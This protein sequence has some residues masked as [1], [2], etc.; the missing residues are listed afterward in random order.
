MS[1]TLTTTLSMFKPDFGHVGWRELYNTNLDI[2][3]TR[4]SVLR[5]DVGNERLGIGTATPGH[6]V[7]IAKSQSGN[8]T[9]L[10]VYN[11]NGTNS[12]ESA[13]ISLGRSA[14]QPM[15]S[16]LAS[17]FSSGTF[18]NGFLAFLTYTSNALTEKMRLTHEGNLGLG[19]TAPVH[20]FEAVG[21]L[22]SRVTESVGADTRLLF[23]THN[24]AAS[25][26][27]N[28][29][30]QILGFIEDGG[31]NP[32]KGSLRLYTNAGDNSVERLRITPDGSMLVGAGAPVAT[33]RFQID[34]TT[35]GLLPPRMTTTQRDAIGSPNVGLLI[36]N[37][38][39][40]KLNVRGASAW[41][42]VTSA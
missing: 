32:L 4:F 23:L 3:D 17:N 2:L 15:G 1:Y 22:V 20:T 11:S 14:T 38:T 18:A 34:S 21:Y 13:S 33:A 40:N 24:G 30:A 36:F 27:T 29:V 8:L 10:W 31:A 37:T 12:A 35:Q 28:Q 16:L 5:V 7:V 41:E 6:P 42:A 26:S 25:S 39:T 19:L 9:G